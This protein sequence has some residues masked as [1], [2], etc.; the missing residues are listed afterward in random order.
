MVNT[1]HNYSPLFIGCIT[2]WSRVSAGEEEN[3]NRLKSIETIETRI[4]LLEERTVQ[5]L[6]DSR[7]GE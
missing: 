5:L 1:I 2:D 3:S 4:K 6:R 7:Q